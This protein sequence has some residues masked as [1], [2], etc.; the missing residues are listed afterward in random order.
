LCTVFPRCETENARSTKNWLNQKMNGLTLNPMH[1]A[2]SH[3][4]HFKH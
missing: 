1:L 3:Q 4:H 2:L